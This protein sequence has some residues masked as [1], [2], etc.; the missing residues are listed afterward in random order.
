M[1]ADRFAPLPVDVFAVLEYEPNCKVRHA[2]RQA[3]VP[4]DQLPP[5]CGECPQEQFHAATEYDVL[6]G[7]AAGGGKTKALVMEGIRKCI[8]H[9]GI[10][11]GAFRRTNAELEESMIAEL[12]EVGYAKALGA[13]WNA[14][15]LNLKFPN[16]SLM[17]FRYAENF[18]D[19]TRRQGGQYQ[20]LLFDERTLTPPDVCQFLESRLRSGRDDIPVIG[21]R[22]GTNPGGVGHGAT[23]TR[24]IDATD[25]GGKI[26]EGPHGQPLRFIPSRLT[27]NPHLN[28]EYERSLDALDEKKRAAFKDGS[29]DVFAGQVFAE[30][31][32]ERH[33]LAPIT[34]PPEWKRYTGTDWGYA[35]PWATLWTAVDEDGR[36]WIYRELYAAQ[37][38]EAEQARRILEAEAGEHISGRWADDAMWA[39]RGDAKPIA[40][41][42]AENGVPLT[43]A[44]KG[45]G[46][47][48]NG[49]QRIH[50]YLREAPACSHHRALGWET[51]PMVHVFT[52]CTE[53]IRTLPVLPH[54]TT[55]NPEDADTNAEDHAP[56]ALRYIAINLGGGPDFLLGDDPTGTP[57]P[58]PLPYAG[59]QFAI[60]PAH[61]Q[62]SGWGA[63]DD[64]PDDPR[65]KVV[66][67]P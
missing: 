36:M 56:D 14:S 20:L 51:C 44:G 67:A 7:G 27:D 30:W 12:A 25:R 65:G 50:S 26:I 57:D 66:I 13:T 60:A 48:V 29:W 59:G 46:S 6:Y 16:G 43:A 52:T 32:H 33:T 10:R 40:N 55:G 64:D 21:I 31:R 28:A 1:L 61:E 58:T 11:V 42:Y 37:V 63:R 54:A 49:W 15:K 4:E 62:P 35:A 19:A 18:Q 5:G 34:L 8:E 3:G 45:P 39:A 23:K 38:G 2:A 24:Y 9:P 22:S 41:V 47:R 53:L 17:M